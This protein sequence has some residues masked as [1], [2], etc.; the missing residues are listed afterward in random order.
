M[1]KLEKFQMKPVCTCDQFYWCHSDVLVVL[2]SISCRKSS[3]SV[4]KRTVVCRMSLATSIMACS[5]MDATLTA[6]SLFSLRCDLPVFSRE[7]NIRCML[8]LEAPTTNIEPTVLEDHVDFNSHTSWRRQ[9]ITWRTLTERNEYIRVVWK[10]RTHTMLTF[11]PPV[12]CSSTLC[13]RA[14]LVV[15]VDVN[16]LLRSS[17]LGNRRAGLGWSV[18]AQNYT[19]L[20]KAVCF[21]LFIW[22][23]SLLKVH[24]QILQFVF[25]A[26]GQNKSYHW[27]SSQK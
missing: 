26:L 11:L 19:H 2:D 5:T 20:V 15:A 22:L 14:A 24:E 7:G 18:G 23:Y 8:G 4:C 17:S 25:I 16:I 9:I 12:W 1:N 3:G 13:G 21:V 6:M 10:E 27:K